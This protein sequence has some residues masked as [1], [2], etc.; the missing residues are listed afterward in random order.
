MK[1]TLTHLSSVTHR[2]SGS[3][4]LRFLLR[5]YS[6]HQRLACSRAWAALGENVCSPSHHLAEAAL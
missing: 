4:Q 3:R 6:Q 2:D 1:V 5:L